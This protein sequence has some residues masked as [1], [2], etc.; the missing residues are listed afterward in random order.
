MHESAFGKMRDMMMESSKTEAPKRR[1]KKKGAWFG[2]DELKQFAQ[3]ELAGMDAEEARKALI[4]KADELMD[5]KVAEI[6]QKKYG[7]PTA[8]SGISV[9]EPNY[10]AIA[11][12][13]DNVSTMAPAAKPEPSKG[14][15]PAGA[16]KPGSESPD[17][18]RK[19]TGRC[20]K[21]YHW[22]GSTCKKS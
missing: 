4:D 3:T 2:W 13:A 20:P 17:A 11:D 7:D 8:T 1:G 10:T 9:S 19:R 12:L 18:F 15:A 22:D 5:K 16:Q 21:G 14:T 6:A